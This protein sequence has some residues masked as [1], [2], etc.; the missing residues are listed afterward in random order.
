MEVG[1]VLVCRFD[2]HVHVYICVSTIVLYSF[3]LWHWTQCYYL[4]FFPLS[5][6]STSN[7]E[8]IDKVEAQLL[9]MQKNIQDEFDSERKLRVDMENVYLAEIEKGCT[10]SDAAA[11]ALKV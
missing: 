8:R 6:S 5:P 3:I 7:R 1:C 11:N 4:S 2:M 9:E 10:L